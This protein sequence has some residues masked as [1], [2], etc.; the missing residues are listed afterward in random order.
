MKCDR[1][2]ID[3]REQ[4]AELFSEGRKI[5]VYPVSTGETG[6]GS[7]YGSLKTPVGLFRIA[8][9]F[10]EGAPIGTIFKSRVSTGKVWPDASFPADDDLVL[11]RVLWLE[12][13]EPGN[14]NTKERFVYLHGTNQESLLGTP[15]SHG[16]IRFRNVDIIE[17]FDRVDVGTL[18]EI[19]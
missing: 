3:A 14:A 6:L 15:A 18:V 13:L 5:G 8:E 2:V 11:T 7:E 17:V 10:G 1:I 12:G 4:R 19:K 9:K 16:C